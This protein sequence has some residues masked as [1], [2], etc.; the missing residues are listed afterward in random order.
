MKIANLFA[1][2]LLTNKVVLWHSY[3][4]ILTAFIAQEILEV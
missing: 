2:I 3:G 4:H 1:I